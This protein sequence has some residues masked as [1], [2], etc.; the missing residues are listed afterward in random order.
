VAGET[1]VRARDRCERGIRFSAPLNAGG[2]ASTNAASC[3][4]T[5]PSEPATVYRDAVPNESFFMAFGGL[6]VTLAGFAGII[7]ALSPRTSAPSAVAVYR[8]RTIV[9]LG[10]AMTVIGFGTV[11]VYSVVAPDVT[12]TV[13]VATVAIAV[14]FIRGLLIDSRPG[15]AWPNESERVM[16]IAMLLVMIVLTLGNLAVASVG[17]LQILFVL[18]LIGPLSIFYNT[19]RDAT[20]A[21]SETIVQSSD[22]GS[23]GSMTGEIPEASE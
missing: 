11:A 6:G 12:L 9:I 23:V 4:Y 20:G 17:Y 7:N 15:A 5:V 10:L 16:T 8:V 2:S 21:P 18:L 19:I 22:R 14:T 13:R 1:A 3:D